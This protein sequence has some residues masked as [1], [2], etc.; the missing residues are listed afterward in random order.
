[1]PV[2]H[3]KHQAWLDHVFE[4]QFDDDIVRWEMDSNGSW[5]RCGPESFTD[6]DAQ[7]RFYHWVADRQKR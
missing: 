7:E 1:M 5:Q 6:G 3:P 2:T 4:I